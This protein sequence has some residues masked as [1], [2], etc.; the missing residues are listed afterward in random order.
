MLGLVARRGMHATMRD[1]A[2]LLAYIITGGEPCA[3][4]WQVRDVNDDGPPTFED[5]AYY[6]L[7][8]SGRS[9][10]FDAIRATFDP[11]QYVDPLVDMA[12]WAGTVRDGWL[13]PNVVISQ[14]ATLLDLRA[15]KRRYFLEH[16]H[17]PAELIERMLPTT[18]RIFDSLVTGDWDEREAVEELINMINV[19]YAPV[20]EGV[21]TDFR[22]RLRLWNSHRYS[23]GSVPGYVAMRS[24]ASDNLSLYYPHLVPKLGDVLDVRRDHVLLGV[25]RWRSG[26]PALRIDWQM[27]QA[28][29]AARNGTPINVQPFHVLRRLDL[30]LR[31]LGP[32]AGGTREIERIEWS[33][34]RGR[35]PVSV[36]VNRTL[37]RYEE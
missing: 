6:N 19:L 24:I 8:F 25:R 32:D 3:T 34:Q 16:D 15:L 29:V 10:L 2:G 14:P 30:F 37:R 7:L 31:S 18:G 27:Y 33:D 4:R 9:K 1:L 20:R 11:A 28:L 35:G 17:E 5:Y 26:D 22:F 21:Q 12:L 23:A 13:M 36:R